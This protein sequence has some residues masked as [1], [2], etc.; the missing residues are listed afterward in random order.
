MNILLS[1]LHLGRFCGSELAT[2]TMAI[3]LS[4]RRYNIDIFS[5][6]YGCVSNMLSKIENINIVKNDKFKNKYDLCLLN[7]KDCI[8][9]INNFRIDGKIVQTMRGIFIRH[10]KPSEYSDYYVST[11]E[12]IKKYA[13]EKH[14]INSDIIRT[15]IDCKRF[16]I[17][18]K[19]DK[20]KKVLILSN[21]GNGI[22]TCKKACDY[23]NLE[24]IIC[25]SVSEPKRKWNVED[26]I[27]ECELVITIGRGVYES[28]ACGRNVVVFDKRTYSTGCDGFV[29]PDNIYELR[30]NN[31]SGRRYLYNYS[32]KD[33]AN[34]I[35]KYDPDISYKLREY[36][37]ENNEVNLVINKYLEYL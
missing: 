4:K 24:Y 30:K 26:Y 32:Y 28:M 10:E 9:Y 18:N 23:L 12:E 13:K 25:G 6:H 20:L 29:T 31:C 8:N 35:K 22:E 34:E 2:Y 17:K 37:L 27:N 5:L 11:S 14:N 36:V 1:N 7:H 33:L 16:N 19:L 3:E 21:Y 15:A